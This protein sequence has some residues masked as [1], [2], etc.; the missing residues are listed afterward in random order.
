MA[1]PITTQGTI[2][3]AQF[4][5]VARAIVAAIA[6]TPIAQRGNSTG[7]VSSNF[8]SKQITIQVTLD[9]DQIVDDQAVGVIAKNHL[10]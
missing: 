10:I 7:S 8:A 1:A 3:E 4:V 2:L 5:E 9:G 6:A